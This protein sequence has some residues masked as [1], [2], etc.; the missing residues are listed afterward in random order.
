MLAATHSVRAKSFAA[1]YK[2]VG[3]VMVVRGQLRIA[4]TLTIRNEK[5][6]EIDVVTDPARLNQLDVAVVD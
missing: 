4:L 3:L 5:I 1:A 6:T 2:L